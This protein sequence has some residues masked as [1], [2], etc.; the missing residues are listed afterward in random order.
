[1]PTAKKAEAIASLVDQ[2]KASRALVLTDYRGLP[3]PELNTLRARLKEAGAEYQVVKNTLLVRAARQVGVS[4]LEPMLEGP[5][6]MAFSTGKDAEVAR[7]VA[8]YVRVSRTSLA[9][10]GGLLGADVLSSQQVETLAALPPKPDLQARLAGNIQGPLSG[11]VGLLNSAL[12]E[13]MSVLEERG[14]QLGPAAA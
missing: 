13:L 11:F 6:A 8:D 12:S 7:A 2:L 1:M 4:G 5:T 9:I 3:T 10:K 14:K